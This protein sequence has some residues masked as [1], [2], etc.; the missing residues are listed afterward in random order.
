MSGLLGELIFG[1]PTSRILLARETIP[2]RKPAFGSIIQFISQRLKD[3][4]CVCRVASA[5]SIS[6]LYFLFKLRLD[7][8]IAKC[9]PNL[10][11]SLPCGTGENLLIFLIGP[12]SINGWVCINF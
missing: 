3:L 4:A 2:D 7:L 8:K 6:A 11:I 5:E 10:K 12:S 1:W 9:E